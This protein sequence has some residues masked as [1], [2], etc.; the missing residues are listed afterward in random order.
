V[1]TEPSRKTTP[2]SQM[3]FTSGLTNTR[4]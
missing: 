1:I 2:A 3:R 4:K